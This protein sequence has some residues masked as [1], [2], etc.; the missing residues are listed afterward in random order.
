MAMDLQ[1]ALAGLD[2]PGLPVLREAIAQGRALRLVLPRSSLHLKFLLDNAEPV[3]ICL[4]RDEH[5]IGPAVG[6]FG[7]RVVYLGRET[8][9][10]GGQWN[11]PAIRAANARYYQRLGALFDAMRVE[12]LVIFLATEPLE[13]FL[14]PRL[15]ATAVE[16]WEDGLM[17]YVDMEG[18][19]FRLKRRS[20]QKLCGF[21]VGR[22]AG[23]TLD[24]NAYRI[25]DRFRE[26][27]L[28]FTRP[29]REQAPRDEILFIGQPLVSD[30]MVTM[31]AY[32]AGLAALAA[33]LRH[34]LRY[35]AHPR[36]SDA[37][38]R[39]L[40]ALLP[41]G[42]LIVEND[43]RGVLEHCA[44]WSYRAYLSPFSTALL[45]LGETA[46]SFW[47]AGLVGLDAHGQ[48]L[49][50]F[51]DSPVAILTSHDELA[52]RLADLSPPLA[53]QP[54]AGGERALAAQT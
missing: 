26:G 27:S 29:E 38:V 53:T 30:G 8:R 14:V 5:M 44:D 35:L 15:P 49:R 36:E 20:V 10:G 11:L 31:A 1:A 32:G 6:A 41:P 34:P 16:V 21:H 17:H 28:T 43:R 2:G 25:R 40:A 50:G 9:I 12:K 37:A 42:A 3:D 23:S 46:R 7:V 52:E 33:R 47:V 24:K 39:E 18:T 19:S 45:D 13:E 48:R 54:R 22:L 51:R 4:V